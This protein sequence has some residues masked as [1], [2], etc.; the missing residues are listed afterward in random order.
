MNDILTIGDRM[1]G[2][3]ILMPQL[4]RRRKQSPCSSHCQK[5]WSRRRPQSLQ[6]YLAVVLKVIGQ[7]YISKKSAF[8]PQAESATCGVR[9]HL[10]SVRIITLSPKNEDNHAITDKLAGFWRRQPAMDLQW[11]HTENADNTKSRENIIS[12]PDAANLTIGHDTDS[13]R[14]S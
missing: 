10:R 6:E 7:E 5:F 3:D 8:V 1:T 2:S 14:P 12:D 11:L 13:E 9:L 4:G